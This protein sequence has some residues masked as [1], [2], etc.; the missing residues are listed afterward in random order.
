MTDIGIFATASRGLGPESLKYARA[1]L[2]QGRSYQSVANIMEMA[3]ADLRRQLPGYVPAH[4][5]P[6]AA[7]NPF[8]RF[9]AVVPVLTPLEQRQGLAMLAR[10]IDVQQGRTVLRQCLES[11]APGITR[12][13][14]RFS[15]PSVPDILTAAPRL[16]A[17]DLARWLASEIGI[18]WADVVGDSCKRA[19]AHPRQIIAYIVRKLCPHMSYPA[20]AKLVGRVD[21]TTIVHAVAAVEMRSAKDPKHADMVADLKAAAQRHFGLLALPTPDRFAMLCEDYAAAMGAND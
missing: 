14:L 2:E 12:D 19:I 21:H 3:E 5:E 20:I 1:L 17:V 6:P 16:R 8:N 18:E 7:S 11:A 9:A 15:A 10:I 13:G 4:R